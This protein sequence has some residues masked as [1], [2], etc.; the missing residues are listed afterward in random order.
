VAEEG[1]AVSIVIYKATTKLETET[2]IA[3]QQTTV[4]AALGK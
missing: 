4:D 1:A 3:P 2:T